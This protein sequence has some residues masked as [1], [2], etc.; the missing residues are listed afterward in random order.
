M[1]LVE[2]EQANNNKDIY[3]IPIVCNSKVNIEPPR[4]IREITQSAR[5]QRYGHTKNYYNKQARCVK[6]AGTHP[7]EN[8]PRGKRI[9]KVVCSICGNNPA[10]YKGCMVR[11]ELQKKI[12][13][14]NNRNTKISTITNQHCKHINVNTN[15]NQKYR[16]Y[17]EVLKPNNRHDTNEHESK[18]FSCKYWKNLKHK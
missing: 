16:N 3:N 13:S 17:A 1:F 14:P 18:Q 10:N 2:I 15:I 9:D 8:C 4:T 12:I 11:K 6:C 5:C 7:T